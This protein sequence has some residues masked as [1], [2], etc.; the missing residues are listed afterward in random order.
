MFGMQLTRWWIFW[1]LSLGCWGMLLWHS[2]L[3]PE[4]L[5]ALIAEWPHLGHPSYLHV[6]EM[7]PDEFFTATL[8][9]LGA[10]LAGSVLLSIMR[11]RLEHLLDHPHRL[12][13]LAMAPDGPHLAAQC[14]NAYSRAMIVG[15][16]IPTSAVIG[17]L[18][19]SVHQ[20]AYV[21]VDPEWLPRI[22]M[23]AATGWLIPLTAWTAAS[24]WRPA[25]RLV[26]IPVVA[27]YAG[28]ALVFSAEMTVRGL[29]EREQK[30][31]VLTAASS[32]GLVPLSLLTA[33]VRSR[34]QLRFLLP[35]LW[36]LLPA[37]LVVASFMVSSGSD[38]F[39]HEARFLI[40]QILFFAVPG[41]QI[42][43]SYFII[44]MVDR[45]FYTGEHLRRDL[46]ARLDQ[47][48]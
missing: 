6:L 26:G 35:L 4:I 34:G 36:G 5:G 12:A 2:R 44:R 37:G 3:V 14:Y 43:A 21:D 46:L 9:A 8:W 11:R 27:A 45:I 28:V 20:W 47:Q 18:A 22:L 25:L 39:S 48:R 31:M 16:F 42:I 40:K 30:A 10:L 41:I 7:G 33:R 19:L 15:V 32:L 38:Y 24:T 1:I 29:G 17:L 13:E 23:A